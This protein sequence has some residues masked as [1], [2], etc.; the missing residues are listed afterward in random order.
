M[1]TSDSE[2]D[3]PL[4]ILDAYHEKTVIFLN[5][6]FDFFDAG[7]KTSMQ[8]CDPKWLNKLAENNSS[9][10]FIGAPANDDFQANVRRSVFPLSVMAGDASGQI[11]QS[12]LFSSPEDLVDSIMQEKKLGAFKMSLSAVKVKPKWYHT[13]RKRD[14]KAAK[15]LATFL[16]DRLPNERFVISHSSGQIIV[17]TGLDHHHFIR[18]TESEITL[19]PASSTNP[20]PSRLDRL[21]K[22]IIIAAIPIHQRVD[23]LWRSTYTNPSVVEAIELS[24]ISD[25]IEQMAGLQ[26]SRYKGLIRMERG[27]VNAANSVIKAHLPSLGHVLDHSHGANQTSPPESIVRVMAWVLAYASTVK[28]HRSLIDVLTLGVRNR[29]S[30]STLLNSDSFNSSIAA[31][32]PEEL[33]DRISNLTQT[34][35]YVLEKG[36]TSASDIVPGTAFWDPSKWNGMVREIEQENRRLQSD[37]DA[38]K[39]ELGRM[40]M[41]P[42]STPVDSAAELSV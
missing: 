12:H 40:L 1:K 39:K 30:T 28:R 7:A 9:S 18:S 23:M 11:K 20:T 10:L 5:D 42:L 41:D 29:S 24:V 26:A 36:Q 17:S 2:F 22:Y 21:S 6:T 27:D 35:P 34:A 3:E 37:M 19:R 25:L 13:G 32:K 8:L 14:E 38:A 31:C 33:I 15:S 4:P 16:H